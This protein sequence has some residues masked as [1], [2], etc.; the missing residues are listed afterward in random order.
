MKFKQ[1]NCIVVFNKTKEK[2]LFC[3]REKEPY[4]GLY[5]FVG[6]KLEPDEASEAAAYRELYEETG[7]CRNDISLFRLMDITYYQQKFILEIYVGI[8]HRDVELLEEVNPLEWI[9]I[10]ENFADSQKY[11]GDKNIAHI[12]EAALKY[13]MLEK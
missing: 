2:L 1:C 6:G 3:K 4:K 9:S 11:A 10:S 13:D 7:I 5:N 12:V 8:L